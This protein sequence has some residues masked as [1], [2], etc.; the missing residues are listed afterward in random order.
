MKSNSLL[1]VRFDSFQIGKRFVLLDLVVHPDCEPQWDSAGPENKFVPVEVW[2]LIY[3][4]LEDLCRRQFGESGGRGKDS[5]G[6]CEI[7]KEYKFRLPEKVNYLLKYEFKDSNSR[8][9]FNTFYNEK[10]TRL[11]K[12]CLVVQVIDET[13]DLFRQLDE[14]KKTIDKLQKENERLKE[15]P[16][17]SQEYT[18]TP[19]RSSSRSANVSLEYIPIAINGGSPISSS[20]Y[21]ARKIASTVKLEPDP[22]TPTSSQETNPDKIAYVPS[23]LKT[24][25][26]ADLGQKVVVSSSGESSI[27]GKRRRR[28]Q[29]EI[30]GNSDDEDDGKRNPK[31]EPGNALNI[32]ME[33]IFSPE[34]MFSPD[35]SPQKPV[36][37]LGDEMLS[38]GDHKRLQLPRK[39]KA[40]VSY[41]GMLSS[42]F[43][44]DGTPPPSCVTKRRRK[45]EDP[46]ASSSKKVPTRG[47]IEGWLSKSSRS[48]GESSTAGCSKDRPKDRDTD[49]RSQGRKPKKEPTPPIPAPLVVDL[50]KLKEEEEVM[51]KTMASLDQ[52]DRM[53]P[54]DK[55]QLDVPVL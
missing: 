51:R 17:L 45:E 11:H 20:S 53:L 46:G 7:D 2:K 4:K 38:T 47:T 44:S 14:R 54:E 15:I 10:D 3:R 49:K 24:P 30:F 39:T 28:R 31:P 26:K 6:R 21:K 12:E 8:T 36:D 41:G 40:G 35:S 50:V 43:S 42:P 32:S 25:S 27:V 55:T 1:I 13:K 33:N 5:D 34:N 16:E 22:Y 19:V 18:P 48:D 37:T 9:L 29:K 23:I 52:L